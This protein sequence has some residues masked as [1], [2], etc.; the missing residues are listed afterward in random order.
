MIGKSYSTFSCI[1]IYIGRGVLQGK[2]VGGKY[3]ASGLYR[4]ENKLSS[5]W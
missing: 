5:G 3:Y 4:K 2:H 1:A